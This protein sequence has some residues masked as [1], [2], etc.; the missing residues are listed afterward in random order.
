[1]KTAALKKTCSLCLVIFG[2]M[3]TAMELGAQ[4]IQLRGA[5]SCGEWVKEKGIQATGNQTWLI[6]YLSG[7]A[8]ATNKSFLRGTDNQS[9]F[10]WVDNYCQAN[11]LMSLAD[12][13]EILYF[14]L[15]KQKNL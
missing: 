13:G 5:R 2:L 15:V 8:V 6:G 12:A 7:I 3:L 9:I 11:P 4:T 14:E 1:M 10:L